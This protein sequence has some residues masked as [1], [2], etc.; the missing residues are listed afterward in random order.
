MKCLRG[1]PRRRGRGFC[2]YPCF[3]ARGKRWE[4]IGF[5]SFFTSVAF[6]LV[7]LAIVVLGCGCGGEQ[8]LGP[9]AGSAGPDAGAAADGG[10]I[11]TVKIPPSPPQCRDLLLGEEFFGPTFP[12]P[13]PLLINESCARVCHNTVGGST[14]VA[15]AG[16]LVTCDACEVA[17]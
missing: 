1:C 15:L 2:C 10:G 16:G 8:P 14:C 6:A 17:P 7:A 13:S 3:A 11:S 12:G 5:W 9:D 4:A